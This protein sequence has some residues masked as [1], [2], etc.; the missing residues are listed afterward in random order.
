MHTLEY[1]IDQARQLPRHDQRRLLKELEELLDQESIVEESLVP[2]GSYSRSLELAGTLHT[3]FTDV[4]ADKYHHLAE[5][6]ADRDD[7]E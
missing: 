7:P 1:I 6:Y 5:A 4:S 3:E 2:H